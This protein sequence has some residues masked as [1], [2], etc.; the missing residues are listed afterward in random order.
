MAT[1]QGRLGTVLYTDT[2]EVNRETSDA[3]RS[4]FRAANGVGFLALPK[5]RPQHV[6]D[7]GDPDSRG[8]ERTPGG[9]QAPGW[10][11]DLTVNT[12]GG[13]LL[14]GV[15]YLCAT[16]RSS[17]YRIESNPGPVTRIVCGAPYT[18]NFTYAI[19]DVVEVPEDKKSGFTANYA[20]ATAAFTSSGEEDVNDA[21]DDDV[22]NFAVWG[23]TSTVPGRFEIEVDNAT[24]AD[25]AEPDE[26][27]SVS[28]YV[29]RLRIYRTLVNETD[30]IS[31]AESQ[32]TFYFDQEVALETLRTHSAWASGTDYTK[33]DYVT[34]TA[35][36][37]TGSP[38]PPGDTTVVSIYEFVS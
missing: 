12:T 35:V 15:Y 18:Q 31:D 2:N 27:T 10:T 17:R 14:S 36:T 33:G 29:D 7:R 20:I 37:G 24:S 23:T 38:P 34:S 4:A 3:N 6:A 25:F 28:D 1:T 22:G 5:Q 11:L 32:G 19:G 21:W 26:N 9:I 8:F 13:S 16:L 30:T